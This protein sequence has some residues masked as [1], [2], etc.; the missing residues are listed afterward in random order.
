MT[1]AGA[2]FEVLT[3]PNAMHAFTNHDAEK[4]GVPGLA[5]NSDADQKSWDATT[6]RRGRCQVVNLFSTGADQRAPDSRAHT[7]GD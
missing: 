1:A 2:K 7:T 6:T 5:Y 4:M 3:Y